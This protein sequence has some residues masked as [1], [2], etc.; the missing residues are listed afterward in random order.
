MC[1]GSTAHATSVVSLPDA[2]GR[3][4]SGIPSATV[5]DRGASVSSSFPAL[6]RLAGSP[7]LPATFALSPGTPLGWNL[8]LLIRKS[9]LSLYF[10][11]SIVGCARRSGYQWH[12]VITRRSRQSGT[13]ILVCV[14]NAPQRKAADST[15]NRPGSAPFVVSLLV[16]AMRRVAFRVQ[17]IWTTTTRAG[18][19]AESY[20][21][22]VTADSAFSMMTQVGFAPRRFI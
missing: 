19:Y 16:R 21:V 17:H 2:A 8:T 7:L 1:Q 22:P 9:S 14:M 5:F 13:G 12:V 15:T 18:R 4:P 10:S 20:A 11:Y 3:N 6:P